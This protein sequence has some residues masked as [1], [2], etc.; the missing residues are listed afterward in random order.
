MKISEYR[1]GNIVEL[2]NPFMNKIRVSLGWR[3]IDS[4]DSNTINGLPSKSFEPIP[5]T[6][7]TFCDLR[8]NVNDKRIT[9]YEIDLELIS[10]NHYDISFNGEVVYSGAQFLHEL[11]N[12]YLLYTKK[13]LQIDYI[14]EL[15]Y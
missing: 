1:Q 3:R 2:W 7:K 6:T 14:A 4:I 5:L 11:Q 10:P 12:V 13:E 9:N 15:E 8:F